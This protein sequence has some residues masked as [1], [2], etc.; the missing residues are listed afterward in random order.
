MGSWNDPLKI[1]SIKYK[2]CQLVSQMTGFIMFATGEKLTA[3]S[4]EI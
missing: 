3:T 4:L 1:I 2:L